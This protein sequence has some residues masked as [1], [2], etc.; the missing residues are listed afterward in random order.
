M[1]TKMNKKVVRSTNLVSLGLN[2]L[3]LLKSHTY[4]INHSDHE[5]NWIK[6]SP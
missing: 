5:R 2:E 4:K 6:Y 3:H 1:T